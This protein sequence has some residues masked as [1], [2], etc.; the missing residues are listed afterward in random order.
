M[1]VAEPDTQTNK[2]AK[3]TQEEPMYSNPTDSIEV[4]EMSIEKQCLV[5]QMVEK[6]DIFHRRLKLDPHTSRCIKSIKN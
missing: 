2:M 6:L 5:Q 3:D 4:L 1:A